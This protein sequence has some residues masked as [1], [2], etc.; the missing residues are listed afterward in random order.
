MNDTFLKIRIIDYFNIDNMNFNMN[1]SKHKSMII[2]NENM[3]QKLELMISE[4][5]G[6]I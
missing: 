1:L 3:V 5:E 2:S 4:V 6:E